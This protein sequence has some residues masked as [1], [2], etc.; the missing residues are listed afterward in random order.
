MLQEK[1]EN[2]LNNLLSSGFEVSD[3][4]TYYTIK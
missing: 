3:V 4:C 1:I 2:K